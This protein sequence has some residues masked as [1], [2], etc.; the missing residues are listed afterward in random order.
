MNWI[1]L[2]PDSA[3]ALKA[4]EIGADILLKATKVDGMNDKD[5]VIHPDAKKFDRLTFQEVLERNIKVM[6]QTAVALCREV[7]MPIYV[8]NMMKEGNFERLAKGDLTFGTLVS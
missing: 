3:A 7:N 2:H 4:A 1:A 8:F 5:P 6:D